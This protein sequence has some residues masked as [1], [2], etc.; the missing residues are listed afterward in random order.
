MRL[1]IS[2]LALAAIVVIGGCATASKTY[3][4]NG[5][6]GYAINCSG[7][8]LSWGACY[9]KAGD[10]CGADGYQILARNGSTG[11]VAGGGP[12]SFF[13]GTVTHRTLLIACKNSPPVAATAS[14]SS[15]AIGEVAG[16]WS[17]YYIGQKTI[18]VTIKVLPD[19]I[20]SGRDAVGCQLSGR[21]IAPTTEGQPYALTMTSVG[22]P[23]CV[24]ELNGT[25]VLSNVDAH[26][27]WKAHSGEYFYVTLSAGQMRFGAELRKQ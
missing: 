23:Q 26:H 3:M 20:F 24:G 11:A 25:G 2:C 9:Q 7:E 15:G 5:Q 12:G 22:E 13:A 6:A 18:A 8:A 1:I 14:T 17:G 16:D 21:I 4:P 10:I 27:Y 19:G